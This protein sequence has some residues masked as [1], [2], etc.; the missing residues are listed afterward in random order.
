MTFLVPIAP[1]NQELK[2]CSVASDNWHILYVA[3][4]YS[5]ILKHLKENNSLCIIVVHF[6]RMTLFQI[7]TFTIV[8]IL[9]FIQ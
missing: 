9:D 2:L 3:L 5:P 6:N 4:S 8:V 7:Y 1:D